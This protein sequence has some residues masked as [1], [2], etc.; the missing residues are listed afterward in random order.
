MLSSLLPSEG[1]ICVAELMPQ[2]W[3]KHYWLDS[4]DAAERWA[5]ALDRAGKTVFIAQASFKTGENRKG[6][7]AHLVK[8]FFLDI[9]CGPKKPY[10][11]QKDGL[12][13]L[14]GFCKTVGLP[15]PTVINSG[16]GLYAHWILTQA[17]PA[18]LWRGAAELLQKL[19]Q[20]NAPGLDND[21]ICAD[22]ARVLRPVGS[23]NRKGEPKPVS[24][25][26]TAPEVSPIEFI[27]KLKHAADNAKILPT[28]PK[29]NTVANA[30]FLAGLDTQK[31]SSAH[32]IASKCAQIAAIQS[33]QGDVSEPLWYAAVGLLRFTTEAPQVIHDWSQGHRDYT[34]GATDAK[35][36]QHERANV[37]PTTCSKFAAE[38]PELCQ[39]CHYAEKLKSPIILGYAAPKPLERTEQSE[40]PEPP[41]GFIIAKDGIHYSD[42][43]DARMVY[44]YPLWVARIN[45]DFFGESVTLRHWLPNEDWRELTIPSNKLTEPK[46]F[47]SVLLDAHIHVV[48]K[49]NKGL[50]MAYVETFMSK[51]RAAQRIEALSS[52]M[53]WK[54]S[55]PGE[56]SFV[57]GDSIYYKGG[58]TKK[59]G[60]SSA[61]PE[62]VK[63]IA[64]QGDMAE[65]VEN[66]KLF[67]RPN[68]EPLAFELICSA[69][70]AP[71][72]AFSGYP[73][74]MISVRGDSGL[75]KTLTGLMG[76]AAWGDPTRLMLQKNDTP[77]A[78]VAR[79][80]IHG[81]LP[82][83]IDEVT[84]M[85][86]DQVSELAYGVTHGREKL[87]LSRS[88]KERTNVNQWRTLALVT[89]NASLI[90]KLA[91]SKGDC[92]A[93]INRIFEIEMHENQGITSEE[94][95]QIYNAIVN[96]ITKKAENYGQ[97]GRIYVQWLVEN[98]DKVPMALKQITEYLQKRTNAIPSER[99]WLMMGAV[100]IYGAMVAKSLKLSHIDHE[101]LAAWVIQQICAM[102]CTKDSFANDPTSLL[103][104]FID[105][106][107]NSFIAV[108]AYDPKASS[109]SGL[110]R[111]PRGKQ[112]VG[113]IEEDPQLL[114]ISRAA[115]HDWLA[116]RQI[117]LRKFAMEMKN[118]G[119]LG[120]H[121]RVSLGRGTIWSG[122]AHPTWKFDL[123]HPALGI[124][125]LKLVPLPP[126]ES[127]ENL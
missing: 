113:R 78:I 6:E 43:G 108:K 58:V 121:E 13:D 28:P 116:K 79:L 19:V 103:A 54:D 76:L 111:E 82:I 71:L 114:W 26:Y 109:Y 24:I 91:T 66:T 74:A 72:V 37:G 77:N 85:D 99:F 35:I 46:A 117:S 15:A 48:G 41:K 89:T 124:K 57:H 32:I 84:N 14:F 115:L 59:V 8:N 107:S 36:S 29:A 45:V 118:R 70:G 122:P 30:S 27:K 112:I 86:S 50:F 96:P 97:V 62:F 53:G 18:N 93:E 44:P 105:N 51:I 98:Q 106:H 94:G 5:L 92:S 17:I 47:F 61:A 104:E 1:Y 67:N 31:P 69:F 38:N 88:A 20:L 40:Y 87:R 83:F 2:G 7:S 9:D 101:R 110:V 10:P 11:T 64:P 75:G 100:A 52:Q 34:P 120:T 119:L 21:G 56:M 95:L 49:D 3:F 42:G 63:G 33:C 68:L 23:H 60:Y 126:A 73:G 125:R 127:V 65:W 16:N 4:P 80:G 22:R 39:G 25:V 55:A 81:S 102:R 12:Q 123:S 90:D